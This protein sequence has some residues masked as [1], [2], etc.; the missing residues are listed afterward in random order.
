MV[1]VFSACVSA[2]PVPP[3]F[4]PKFKIGDERGTTTPR[5]E[6]PESWCPYEAPDGA[7]SVSFPGAPREST[8]Y[9]EI[10]AIRLLEVSYVVGD[11]EL[12]AASGRIE[13]PSGNRFDVQAGIQG[14]RDA[15]VHYI[16]ARVNREVDI[17]QDGHVGRRLELRGAIEG[18]KVTGVLKIFAGEDGHFHQVFVLWAGDTPFEDA[19]PFL[20]SFSMRK[21][22]YVIGR[23]TRVKQ[24]SSTLPGVCRGRNGTSGIRR[25][26]S[27]ISSVPS[28]VPA[29]RDA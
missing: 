17:L 28:R 20:D 23:Q 4:T 12:R 26:G 7:F 18:K 3:P 6:P 11:V 29:D 15:A 22:P 1:F 21:C 2:R 14:A 27:T 13:I 16:D 9:S 24:R 5:R 10:P 25:S 8:Q 19:E